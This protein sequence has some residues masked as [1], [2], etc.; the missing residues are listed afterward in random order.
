MLEG[1]ILHPSERLSGC[2]INNVA[3]I[4]RQVQME[5]YNSNGIRIS[6][7]LCA[8][9][10]GTSGQWMRFVIPISFLTYRNSN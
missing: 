4:N 2:R 6:V 9:L 1:V 8:V 3:G 5:R 7:L 10:C